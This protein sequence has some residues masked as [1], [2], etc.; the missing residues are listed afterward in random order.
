MFPSDE[1]E[2]GKKSQ[3]AYLEKGREKNFVVKLFTDKL[4]IISLL[5]FYLFAIR[6]PINL[7]VVLIRRIDDGAFAKIR[8]FINPFN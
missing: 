3:N 7:F 4:K 8:D 2:W 6:A 5:G 1:W